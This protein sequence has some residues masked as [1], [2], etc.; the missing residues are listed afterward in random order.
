MNPGWRAV[1]STLIVAALALAGRSAA[2]QRGSLTGA[3][4]IARVYDA[5][6][7]AR[8]AE[9]ST[10]RAATCE[11]TTAT[12]DGRP[13]PAVC[14]LLGVV[15]RWWR[16]QLDPVNT[17]D[18]AAFEQAS[19]AAIAAAEEWT[20]QEPRRAE[21]WFYLGG[22]YGARSQWRV[23][24]GQVVA[25]ARD[26]KRIKES[27]E[28]ALMLDPGLKDAYFGIGLYHYYADVA[29]AAAKLLRFLL[30]LP[31]GAR[32]QG[33]RE[34]REARESGQ[35]LRS[36]AD[37]QLHL[38]YL[39]YEKDP[40]RARQLI[41]DLQN[42]HPHNPHFP[43]VVAEIN[44]NYLH[45]D[46]AS[47]RAWQAMLSAALDGQLAE[48]DL[49]E[50]RARLAAADLFERLHESDKALEHAGLVLRSGA[51]APYGAQ[52][53]AALIQGQAHD[54]LGSRAEALAAYRRA[55]DL[56]RGGDPLNV[57]SRARAGIRRAPDERTARA[58][59]LSLEGWRALERGAL[60]VATGL[61]DESRTLK[62]DDPVTAYRRA[63]LYLAQRNPQA[64]LPLFEQ[65]IAARAGTV[66]PAI[67]GY[68]MFDAATLFEARGERTRAIEYFTY[69]STLFGGDERTKEAA[70]RALR[71]LSSAAHTT[72][73]VDLTH[74]ARM[75]VVSTNFF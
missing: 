26:G 3:D 25:A 18:D 48:P 47:L 50:T 16:I 45:D 43:Q 2:Q 28:R 12:G 32:V 23:L 40:L 58:Y 65:T 55:A 63:R 5:I 29:P 59:R 69:A 64:A 74:S 75:D 37:Y 68:A 14:Q 11:T 20:R 39:W 60:D 73:R 33:L 42:R 21:A 10:L 35:L 66:P 19:T 53:L 4:R 24:R 30:F 54:R 22:A 51:T 13:H 8:F 15:Q 72:T 34:M 71:R 31:G 6:L 70:Q 61:L 62:R 38:I 36:E 7:D 27:L 49:A 46:T 9:A 1:V 57:A 52:A 17:A 41:I 56:A 67:Q 44:D